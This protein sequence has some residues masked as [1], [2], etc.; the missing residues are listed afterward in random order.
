MFYCYLGFIVLASLDNQVFRSFLIK[1]FC[2]IYG[3][4]TYFLIKHNVHVL[5]ANMYK[6]RKLALWSSDVRRDHDGWGTFNPFILNHNFFYKKN[7]NQLVRLNIYFMAQWK[8]VA[9]FCRFIWIKLCRNVISNRF[10]RGAY[11]NIQKV[12]A[13]II[14]R[15]YI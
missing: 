4:Q 13:F 8:K 5:K 15:P 7:L 1:A 10:T 3:F 12:T 11:M 2:P 6:W 9:I 14:F